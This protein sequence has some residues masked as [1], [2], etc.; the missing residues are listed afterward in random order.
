VAALPIG[1][2]GSVSIAFAGQDAALPPTASA[3]LEAVAARMAASPDAQAQI[4]AYASADDGNVSR[5]RRL[6]LSRALATRS[7]LI[8]HG[9]ASSRIDVRALG[10]QVP[11]GAPDRVDVRLI[12]P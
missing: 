8:D 5:A 2:A 9:I 6:S 10:N 7:F 1:P 11:E 4:L 3:E 12:T